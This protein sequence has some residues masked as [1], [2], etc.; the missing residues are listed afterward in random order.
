MRKKPGQAVGRA[1]RAQLQ[2]AS[3]SAAS[4]ADRFGVNPKTVLKWRHRDGVEEQRR[5][6]AVSRST[7]LSLI[8]E[9]VAA[10][11]RH[12][13]RLPLDDVLAALHPVLP[14][15]TRSGLHRLFRRHGLGRLPEAA[16]GDEAEGTWRLDVISLAAPAGTRA[17][18]VAFDAASKF[19][20]ASLHSGATAAEAE[21]ALAALLQAAPE[22]PRVI[23]TPDA[24]PFSG[25]DAFARACRAVG[26]THRIMPADVPLTSIRQVLAADG[27]LAGVSDAAL[28]QHLADALA[29][30]NR[31]CTLRVLKGRAPLDVLAA[32]QARP[33]GRAATV[34]DVAAQVGV[35]PMTVSRVANNDPD[36]SDSTR[37]AVLAAI[38]ALGYV[39]NAS[40]R[41][42]A[43]R[44]VAQ[45]GLLYSNPSAAYLGEILVG[46]IEETGRSGHHLVLER[47]Q[48]AEDERAIVRRLMRRN[49][50]GVIVPPPLCDS[51]AVLQALRQA[52]IIAVAVAG[53]SAD[54]AELSVR[55]DDAAAAEAMTRHLISLGH[56]D[57]GFIKG[58]PNQ[59]AS[60]LREAGFLADLRAAGLPAPPERRAQGYFSYKSGI[61]A[62]HELLSA[63]R[64]TAVLCS[65]D[66]MAAAAVSVAHQNGLAVPRDLSVVGFDDTLAATIVW[67]ALT[68]VRQPIAQMAERAVKLLA[69]ALK[70]REAATKPPAPHVVIPYTITLRDSSAPPPMSSR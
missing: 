50:D 8:E 32:R 17:V 55:I 67:P 5:G 65:N 37:Q 18:F 40:A 6:P 57:I 33:R 19:A 34:R 56:R 61:A 51:P 29:A 68:T 58:N 20:C 62:M 11:V 66:D 25:D 14:R 48:D 41:R 9:A 23:V 59:R 16:P 26:A 69:A 63:G 45:L 70:A 22:R 3:G 24:P 2:N 53:G 44:W 31:S 52:D 35:S 30:Y 13:S 36:V 12:Q 49:I 42:L 1:L 60:G 27:T 28:T 21:A 47:C 46:A 38:E 7:V 39:P 43:G 10:L 15:L 64:P 4:V 54:T